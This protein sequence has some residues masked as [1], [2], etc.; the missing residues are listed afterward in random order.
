MCEDAWGL[1]DMYRKPR[2]LQELHAIREEM[3]RECDYD[4][5][6]LAEMVRSGHRPPHGPQQIIRGRR[7]FAPPQADHEKRQ[8][9]VNET[10][11][12]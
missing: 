11:Y 2:F 8:S 10:D 3:A 12:Q 7:V 1:W 6:L 9:P 5:D 4:V